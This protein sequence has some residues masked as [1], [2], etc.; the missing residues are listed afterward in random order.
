M[1]LSTSTP[2]PSDPPIDAG[3]VADAAEAAGEAVVDL[4]GAALALGVGALIGVVLTILLFR[5]LFRFWR[6]P[7]GMEARRRGRTGRR[8]AGAALG[9]LV[10][11]RTIEL[12]TRI[13]GL[14]Q[15]A[16][17]LLLVAGLTAFGISLLRSAEVAAIETY[18]TAAP[19]NLHARRRRT[20][21]LV[22]R[23]VGT[24]FL[25]LLGL[26]MA[27]L[28]FPSA[29]TVGQS[30]LASAGVIGIIAGVAAQGSLKNLIAGIQIAAAEP[31]RLGD[32]VLVEG[33]WGWVEDITVTTVVIKVWDRRR[34]V[35]PTSWFTENPFQN[36][37]RKDAQLLGQVTLVLDHRADVARLREAAGEAVTASEHWDGETWVVQVIDADEHGMTVRVLMT[38]VDAPTAW[39]LRCEV[40][41]RLLAW[42]VANDPK[43]LPTHRLLPHE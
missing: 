12:G 2:A 30:L 41:E 21:F 33:E 9:A 20:Q 6:T 38:A 8:L 40:R 4:V 37:T 10:A 3:E 15:Q 31:I 16:L 23:R 13:E 22:L 7:F 29:R 34:L 14:V 11:E 43:A 42:L 5:A 36:W 32:A 27:L 39:D 35:Y 19:D 18:D 26:A 24:A 1:L 17:V 28:T 25:I